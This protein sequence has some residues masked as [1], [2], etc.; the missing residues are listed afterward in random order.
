MTFLELALADAIGTG[1]S[2]DL[3]HPKSVSAPRPRR[4]GAV[5][6][7]RMLGAFYTPDDIAIVLTRWALAGSGGTVLDPSYGGCAFLRAAVSVLRDLHVNQ[8]GR[9]V[10]GVD[11]D[12]KCVRFAEGLV[13]PANHITA[14]FLALR[15][16]AV[17][18][19][20]FKAVVGNPPYVRH[21]WLKG[22]KRRAAMSVAERAGVRLQA[23]ASTWAYFV[24]HALEFL[25][26]NGRLALLVPEAVL[27]ADYAKA[28]RQALQQRFARV[29]LVH[30]RDRVFSDTDEPVVVIAA[31]GAGPGELRTEAIRS[32]RDLA[33]VLNRSDS[34]TST[35]DVISNGREVDRRV[36]DLISELS[37]APAFVKL[38]DI[39]RLRI[40][41]VTGSNHFFIRSADE[42]E[43]L[44]MPRRATERVVGRTQWLTGLEFTKSDHLHLTE[45]GRRTLLIRPTSA[46]CSHRS[47]KEWVESG[48]AEGIHQHH[49]CSVRDPWFGIDTGPRPDAF[50]TCS[51]MSS[52]LLVIN[53]SGYRCTNALHSVCWCELGRT[54]PEA[55]VVGFLSSLTSVWAEIHGRRYGGGVLKLEPGTLRTIP[56]PLVAIDGT[57]FEEIDA[58]LRR[59]GEDRARSVADDMVLKKGLGISAK[60]IARL[61]RA[62]KE[63]AR[64][65]MPAR[66]GATDG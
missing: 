10:F 12:R 41:F 22:S 26:P 39:A 55:I 63:L 47:I 11:I 28:I 59:G 21:H 54:S 32:A 52:P 34:F 36:V 16:E 49:K 7:R 57:T 48:E 37:A 33:K 66:N 24:L 20:P 51:R 64:Q 44:G 2:L 50:V 30:V 56:I 53:R 42:V 9:L 23:T 15:P 62:Q 35:Y 40:G 5:T 31:E 1:R 29:A 19:A 6:P 13:A 45:L 18:G 46:T 4:D 38:E 3:A 60:D 8:P 43:H 65:R 17:S 27:Q 14:D 58:L 61:Q 25:A